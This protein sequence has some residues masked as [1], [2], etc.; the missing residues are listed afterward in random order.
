MYFWASIDHLES[1]ALL[2]Y[3][4]VAFLDDVSE[5]LGGPFLSSHVVLPHS[6]QINL[7]T[8]ECGESLLTEQLLSLDEALEHLLVPEEARSDKSAP[9]TDSKLHHSCL[10]DLNLLFTPTL[11]KGPVLKR[12]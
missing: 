8:S 4:P 3:Q 10:Q 11:G 7:Q 5:L 6:I 12:V 1:L 2:T 9:F